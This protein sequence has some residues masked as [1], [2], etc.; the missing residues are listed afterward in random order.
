MAAAA[1]AAVLEPRQATSVAVSHGGG[2]AARRHQLDLDPARAEAVRKEL[3]GL[4]APAEV[5]ADVAA[6]FAPANA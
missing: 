6:R 4:P 3:V 1:L 5:V 2:P